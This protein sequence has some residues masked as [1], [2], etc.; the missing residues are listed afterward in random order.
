M[1][2]TDQLQK[3][4]AS[5]LDLYEQGQYSKAV[6]VYEKILASFPDADL[7]LYNLGLALYELT[8]FDGA[9][10]SFLKAAENNAD[11]PDYWFNAGL[12]LKR[13]GQYQE[14]VA[15]YEKAGRLQ[16]DDADVV[17]NLG[18]CLQAADR[19]PAAV[20][21]Y[22]KALG[23]TV[24]HIP[25]LSNL[26]YCVHRSGDHVRATELYRRLLDL[27]P[28]HV[29]A[30]YMLDALAGNNMTSPPPG[31]VAE[32]F[33]GYSENFDTDLLENLSY[34]VPDLLADLLAG[35]IGR[36]EKNMRVV[37]LGCGTG[38]SGQAI[39][40][41]ARFLVGVDLSAKMVA[42][43]DKKGC[44][45]QL[46]VGDVVDFLNNLN[47]PVDLLLAADVLTY[48]GDLEP[49]FRVASTGEQPGSLFCFSVEHEDQSDWQIRP[50]GRY[51]HH[52]EYISGLA[53][54]HGWEV[55]NMQRARLRKELDGWITGNIY[56]LM[57][58]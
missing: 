57:A 48:F 7:V 12:S 1:A 51:G 24:D 10:A 4:Y 53:Q 52:P 6:D 19:I 38:L 35:Y 42:E 26:A 5:A 34:R 22:E 46:V 11:D 56:L 29:S 18:S 17:Y 27:Q 32:L 33:D 28:D 21:A 58:L 13:A 49:L 9:A 37:D 47:E 39:L 30:R 55:L 2:D 16:P 25:A 36:G 41:F 3:E 20:A 8:D 14:A 44:Y 40:P 50:T 31:Y 15:A 43:A 23:R 45:D 54:N